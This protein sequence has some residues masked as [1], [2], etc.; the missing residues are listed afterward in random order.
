MKKIIITGMIIASGM[1]LLFSCNKGSEDVLKA[2]TTCDTTAVSFSTQIVP[3]LQNN[4]YRCHGSGN[5]GSGAGILLEG[6]SN[7]KTWVDNNYLVNVVKGSS[8][9]IL[10]PYG[11]PKMSDCNV[12]TIAAWVNQGAKNN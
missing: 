2:S 5:T 10:M 3:I 4:C 9:Y 12:N 7:V 6:Y 8:G 11:G 1:A